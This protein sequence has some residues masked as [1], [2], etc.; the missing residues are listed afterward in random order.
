MPVYALGDQEPEIDPSAYI[1]PEATV[2]GSVVIGAESSVWAQAVVRGDDNSITIGAKTSVQDGAVI[3]CTDDEPT[4]VGDRCTIGHL[5]HLEGCTIHDDSLIGSGA[6]VLHKAVVGPNALVG[7]AAMV[8]GGT[9]V[10]PWSMAL[11]VPAQIRRN[12]LEEGF[13]EQNVTSYVARGRRYAAELRR[14]D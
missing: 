5:A 2:I 3:H 13:C 14:L 4:V 12:A 7:A 1:H 11:G 6:I 8:V 9:E 10:S